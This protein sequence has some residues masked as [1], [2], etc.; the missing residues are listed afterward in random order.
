M[1]LP[2]QHRHHGKQHQ[3]QFL[4]SCQL[5]IPQ[6]LPPVFSQIPHNIPVLP[7]L[8]LHILYRNMQKVIQ[9]LVQPEP[10]CRPHK[11]RVIP[12]YDLR[13]H[14]RVVHVVA[15][16]PGK[17]LRRVRPRVAAALIKNIVGSL[18]D[19]DDPLYLR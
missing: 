2:D 19:A 3:I 5:L 8:F 10:L 17:L 9:P 1:H 15:V 18:R 14:I 4:L 7:V 12:L 6:D 13:H 11:P 16:D